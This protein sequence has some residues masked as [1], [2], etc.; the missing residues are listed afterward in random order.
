MK[1]AQKKYTSAFE[2]DVDIIKLKREI[3]KI[4][5][6]IAEQQKKLNTNVDTMLKQDNPAQYMYW[7][8]QAEWEKKKLIQLQ[9]KISSITEMRIPRLARTRADI[10]TVPFSFM[11]PNE[12]A[13]LRTL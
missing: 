5:V 9:K 7:K 1:R 12:G 6:E 8:E 10:S 11:D 13:V 2:I 4:D 3:K